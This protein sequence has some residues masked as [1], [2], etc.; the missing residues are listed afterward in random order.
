M[1]QPADPTVVGH[2]FNPA[3]LFDKFQRPRHL[4]VLSSYLR[5]IDGFELHVV[6][7]AEVVPKEYRYLRHSL[8]GGSGYRHSYAGNVHVKGVHVG[9]K[10][11]PLIKGV[12]PCRSRSV[13]VLNVRWAIHRESHFID[14]ISKPFVV[15]GINL[16]IGDRGYVNSNI[17][18]FCTRSCIFNNA[19][20]TI[21]V[22][23]WFASAIE[24]DHESAA[25]SYHAIQHRI[26]RPEI[27][28]SLCDFP[29]DS[30]VFLGCST[31]KTILAP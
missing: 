5:K 4:S 31:G 16:T 9:K 17:T 18:F 3:K 21:P 15:F 20:K 10:R 27:Y 13:R 28:R 14:V 19:G 23:S 30:S 29:W 7:L 12:F 25:S 22:L 24:A 8:E 2:V 6:L 26:P 1:S 11:P